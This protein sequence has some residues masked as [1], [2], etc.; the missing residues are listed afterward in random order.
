MNKIFIKK[1][2]ISATIL[3]FLACFLLITYIKPNFIYNKRGGLR[4]FGLGKNNSTIF[5]IW[6]LVILIS[7]ISYVFVMF[8]L[9]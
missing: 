3:L 1:H 6:L 7:I 8:Y 5:P 9:L 2:K 4:N